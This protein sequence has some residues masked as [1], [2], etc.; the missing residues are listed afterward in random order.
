[1]GP[2]FSP[3]PS[4]SGQVPGFQPRPSAGC[5]PC[6]GPDCS[7]FHLILAG[8]THSTQPMNSS[9]MS[10][11]IIRHHWNAIL[12]RGLFLLAIVIRL[13]SVCLFRKPGETDGGSLKESG[14]PGPPKH[15]DGHGAVGRSELPPQ[16]PHPRV[17]KAAAPGHGW[18]SPRA[19]GPPFAVLLTGCVTLCKSRCLSGHCGVNL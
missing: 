4:S 7:A 13:V 8:P 9:L 2:A 6:L 15:L 12:L 16:S 5:T 14:I 18:P 19:Q 11:A 17:R 10:A 3:L 1:M